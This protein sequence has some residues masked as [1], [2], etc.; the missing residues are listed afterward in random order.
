MRLKSQLRPWGGG[1][2]LYLPKPLQ[3]AL[4]LE[5][6]D[7]MLLDL[8][9]E[10][11]FSA[12]RLPRSMLTITSAG[13]RGVLRFGE[14]GVKLRPGQGRQLL[15]TLRAGTP[16]SAAPLTLPGALD[17]VSVDITPEQWTQLADELAQWL[18]DA[19]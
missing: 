18:E 7:T 5:R 15:Q 6:G 14:I 16:Q 3:D 17:R 8:V 12:R 4:G 9:D 1:L 10:N 13:R 11:A 2:G 19:E